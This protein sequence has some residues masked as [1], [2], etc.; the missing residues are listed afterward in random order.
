MRLMKPLQKH[1]HCAVLGYSILCGSLLAAAG[2][3]SLASA[4]EAGAATDTAADTGLAEI[5]VTAE[6]YTSTI[7]NTPISITALTGDQLNAAGITSL[8]DVIRE[9]PGLSMRSSGPGLTELEARG[10]ASNGG[11]APTVG[12]YLDEIPLSPP[13]VS[14]SGKIVIDP[15]L[16][17]LDRVEVLRGPQGTLYGSGSMGG[18]VKLVTNQPKLNTFEG[19]FQ[20]TLSDT[21][22]GSGNGGGSVMLNLPAGDMLA[23]R[24]VATDTYRSGWLDRVVVSPFPQDLPGA[25]GLPPPVLRT[26]NVLDA[27][28]QS[29]STNVNTE[30]LYGGRS[31]LLFQPNADFSNTLSFFYQRLVMGGYD[32]VD[33]PPGPSYQAHYE[34]FDIPEP[35][36]DTIHIY[37]NTFVVN[38][39]FADLTS[40]TAY[41]ERQEHQQQ[42]ASES[43]SYAN[44]VYPYESMPY[45][46][47]DNS[48][49]CSQELRLSSRNDDRL[50]WVAG[51]FFSD[52]HSLWNEYG[53]N[54]F[55]AT[56]DN[57]TGI[58]Y[59]S[60]NQYHVD[61]YALFTDGS[62]KITDTLKLSAGLR[63]YRYQSSQTQDE[64][65][66]D[67]PT[68]D[69]DV[70]S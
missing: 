29:V 9:V 41:W 35:I 20:G 61:Q 22:G 63:W 48:Q 51:A 58:L 49:Q 57:P 33:G 66:V 69:T 64:F 40:A 3:S 54:L 4:T 18:T 21:E 27:P 17:D 30:S 25:P 15:D 32:L 11:A 68:G 8:E 55:Y 23:L 45:T 28:V 13:A 50:H 5:V 65:G 43:S 52:L 16:Y 47:T 37:S 7:Q 19:S 1:K 46:E 6:R 24:L 56:P 62:F 14:Q 38:L 60:Y 42:D 34:P 31:T 70:P 36:A 26:P 59:K 10:L 53:A 67:G 12:F 2:W 39:G 44:D